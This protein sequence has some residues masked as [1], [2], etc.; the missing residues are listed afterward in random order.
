MKTLEAEKIQREIF[1]NMNTETFYRSLLFCKRIKK[2][3]LRNEHP[4]W[5][6]EGLK[7]N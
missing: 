6:E 5:T 1:R 2:A 7:R 4:G 3:A